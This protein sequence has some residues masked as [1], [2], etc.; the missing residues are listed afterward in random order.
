[1]E[2]WSVR[3]VACATRL[4]RR[5][6]TGLVPGAMALAASVL[7]VHAQGIVAANPGTATLA[8]KIEGVMARGGVMRLG[9]YDRAS[10]PDDNSQPV[11]SADV[12]A[13]PGETVVTLRNIPPGVYAIQVYEDLNSNGRMDMNW[14]GFPRE[15]YGFSRDA[16][17]GFA[18]PRFEA[19]KITVAAGANAQVINLQNTASFFA[20]R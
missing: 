20:R 8:I 1:M 12:P 14:I 6:A 5:V 7:A 15:P 16:R 19:V 10:Y 9:L 3:I 4:L 17:P 13:L 11:A 2:I 18:K